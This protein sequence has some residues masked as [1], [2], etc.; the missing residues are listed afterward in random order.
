VQTVQGGVSNWIPATIAGN[1]TSFTFTAPAAGN[2]Q[3]N[4][5]MQISGSTWYSGSFTAVVQ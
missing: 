5:S 1:G 4:I 3:F 2:Y